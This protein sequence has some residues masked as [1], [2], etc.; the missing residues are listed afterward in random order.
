MKTK[1]KILLNKPL[2]HPFNINIQIST[3]RCPPEVLEGEYH[4]AHPEEGGGGGAKKV[5]RKNKGE[6]GTN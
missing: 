1:T 5:T 6:G 3:I 2:C 4:C